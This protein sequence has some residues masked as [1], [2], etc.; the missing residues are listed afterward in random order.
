LEEVRLNVRNDKK[1]R[2]KSS[3]VGL[4]KG[5]LICELL[6]EHFYGL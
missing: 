4:N 5:K 6:I 3:F 2:R 1:E